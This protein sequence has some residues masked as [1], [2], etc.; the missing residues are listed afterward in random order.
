MPAR[1]Y[2]DIFGG[3]ALILIGGFIAIH[4]LTTLALGNI[5][6]MGPGMFPAGLGCILSALGLAIVVP[7]LF[8]AA[9]LPS[10]DVRSLVAILASVLAFA[11]LLEPF[12]L[13]PA[14]VGMTLIASRADGKLSLLGAGILAVCLSIG[15]TLIFQ[16]GLG[17]QISI[18]TW[19]W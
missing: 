9:P 12:G 11:L 17:R 13:A 7:A 2:R 4:A 6:N 19:P 1:D 18:L 15:T 10:V 3:G 14:I 16:V 8:R 5:A